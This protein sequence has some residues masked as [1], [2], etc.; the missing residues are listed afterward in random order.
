MLDCSN[1]DVSIVFNN[2]VSDVIKSRIQEAAMINYSMF[3]GNYCGV[4]PNS[5]NH[6]ADY[7]PTQLG[8]GTNTEPNVERF[9]SR[10]PVH[11]S[12]PAVGFQSLTVPPVM[13]SYPGETPTSGKLSYTNVDQQRNLEAARMDYNNRLAPYGGSQD[14]RARSDPLGLYGNGFPWSGNIFNAPQLP[15]QLPLAPLT[16]MTS[17]P[18]LGLEPNSNRIDSVAENVRS[19]STSFHELERMNKHRADT[20]GLYG[21]SAS[22]NN[23]ESMTLVRSPP[24]DTVQPMGNSETPKTGREFPSSVTDGNLLA[25]NTRQVDAPFSIPAIDPYSSVSM[26]MH[27]NIFRV[28]L[29][30]PDQHQRPLLSPTVSS[31]KLGKRKSSLPFRTSK[32]SPAGVQDTNALSAVSETFVYRNIVDPVLINLPFSENSNFDAS[33]STGVPSGCRNKRARIQKKPSTAVPEDLKDDGYWEKRKKNNESAKRSRLGVRMD[34]A[35]A[36]ANLEKIEGEREQLLADIGAMER[37]IEQLR[38][39]GIDI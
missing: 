8:T 30:V 33:L 37:E 5:V 15:P 10:T 29:P 25:R 2:S 16:A 23:L 6:A 9:D 31:T 17:A 24:T 13:T 4:Y 21:G 27:D 32:G 22:T 3:M 28:P 36:K 20:F 18:A 12:Y 11:T 1:D 39:S 38:S 7:Q 19:S 34:E 35:Q 14:I 26:P